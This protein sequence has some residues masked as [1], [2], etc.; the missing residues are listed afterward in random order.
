MIERS[1]TPGPWVYDSGSFYA[2]C[3]LDSAG[4]TK[5]LR[6]SDRDLFEMPIAEIGRGRPENSKANARLIAA[7]PEMFELLE[8]IY[9]RDGQPFPHRYLG[10]VKDADYIRLGEI[11]KRVRGTDGR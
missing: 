9:E 4:L 11:I 5:R 1:W 8:D 2:Q 7:A 10:K 3:Q 6:G